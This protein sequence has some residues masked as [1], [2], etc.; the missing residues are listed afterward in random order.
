MPWSAKNPPRPAKNWPAPAQALCIR[1]ANAALKAGKSDQDAIFACIGAVK[2]KYPK[3]VGGGTKKNSAAD[4]SAQIYALPRLELKEDTEGK[5][6]STLQLLP[7]GKF[8]HPWYGE[9][10]FTMPILR[11]VKRNFDQK[12]LG[13]DIMVDE[14]HDRGKAMGWF[15]E[16]HTGNRKIGDKE[17]AGLFGKVEWT[18]SGLVALK[19]DSYRYFSAEVGSFTDAE[20]NTT[21]NVLFGGGLTN[22]PFFKQ[23]PA[24]KLGEGQGE[25]RFAIGLFGDPLWIFADG[26][27]DEEEDEETE[28]TFF[29]GFLAD[30]EFDEDTGEEDDDDTEEDEEVKLADLIKKLNKDHGLKLSDD[31]SEEDVVAA[32]G[33][34]SAGAITSDQRTKLVELGVKFDDTKPVGEAIVTALTALKVKAE[35]N[36]DAI[37]D[38]RK[39]LADT[40]AESA[41]ATLIQ[42]GKLTPAQKERYIKLYHTDN[43]LFTEMTKD[44]EPV[45][46]LGEV[47]GDGD[48]AEPG[49]AKAGEFKD[50]AKAT[51]ESDRYLNLVPAVAER[52][53]TKKNGKG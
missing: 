26:E 10:D 9:L 16:I 35:D 11:A 1:V 5:Q 33:T 3:A 36:A 18:E 24:V 49:S 21:P 8:Q 30:P 40:K 20:G 17:V 39:E 51:E 45:V 48:P 29:A 4:L 15:K 34:V 7:E 44:L 46:Q 27:D 32:F 53:A 52:L 13:T 6:T 50:P 31:A 14:G 28:R 19:S 2:R 12:V 25:D 43:A 37:K 23:M 47:G 42:E 22:R 38:I 41:V